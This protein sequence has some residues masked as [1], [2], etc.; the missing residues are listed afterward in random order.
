MKISLISASNF[1]ENPS[2]IKIDKKTN[3]ISLAVPTGK[4]QNKTEILRETLEKLSGSSANVCYTNKSMQEILDENFSNTQKRL[5]HTVQS[6]HHSVCDHA[7]LTLYLEDI[8]KLFA[9]LLNNEKDYSTSEKSGRYAPQ[10]WDS[11]GEGKL[12]LKWQNIIREKID[13]EYGDSVAY[14]DEN[15]KNKLAQENGR[16]FLS[17][18]EPTTKMVHTISWRQLNYEVCWMKEILEK[19]NQSTIIEKLK[20][21]MKDFCEQIE[22]LDLVYEGIVDG[23]NRTFS[24]FNDNQTD[25]E[26]FGRIYTT[27]YKGSF[28]QVAQAQ[29]HRTIDYTIS[30][31]QEFDF[32]VPEILKSDPDLVEEYKNDAESVKDKFPQGTMVNVTESGTYE[33]FKWKLLERKCARAQNEIRLQA[34]ITTQK[35]YDALKAKSDKLADDLKNYL[36]AS[37][38][39][40]P[41]YKCREVCGFK[42]GIS[43]ERKI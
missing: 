14:L 9:I 30:I 40:F 13:E 5:K 17:V 19:K 6:G 4:V 7:N 28:T 43:G 1:Y 31:P 32:Y 35:Y 11:N 36:Q 25:E 20:P 10:N 22:K 34:N 38:C 41:N 42:Q 27:N 37:R 29:R 12:C 23:K 24:L 16:Y 18:L 15:R 39:K 21:T 8:P 2:P 33:A 26:Y 3:E